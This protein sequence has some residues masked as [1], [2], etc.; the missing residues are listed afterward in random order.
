MVVL[1]LPERSKIMIHAPVTFAR[2]GPGMD[3]RGSVGRL[4]CHY[5]SVR[6]VII[7]GWPFLPTAKVLS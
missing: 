7:P 1:L 4:S 6:E 3:L 2:K 5:L